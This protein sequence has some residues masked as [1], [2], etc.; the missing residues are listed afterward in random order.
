[1]PWLLLSLLVSVSPPWE[2]GESQSQDLTI[3]LVTFGP[4]DSLTQWWG[5]SGLLVAD[6]RLG[7]SRLYNY[8]MFGFEAG[9]VNQFV[10]G[11]LDFWVDDSIPVDRTFLLYANELRRD[12]RIQELNLTPAQAATAAAKLAWNVRPE[13]RRYL[14]QHYTDNCS[15]RPRD[16]I[17]EAIGGQL[18]AATSGPA[19]MTLREHTLR[20]SCVDPPM[21]LVLDYLQNGSLDGPLTQRGEAYLPDELERQVARLNVIEKDGSVRPLVRRQWV[22]FASGRK[23]PPEFPP[24]WTWELLAIGMAFLGILAGLLNPRALRFRGTR[25]IAGTGVALFGLASGILGCTLFF[26]GTFTDHL[27]AHHNENI[28]LIS[29]F[30]LVLLPVGIQLAMGKARSLARLGSAWFWLAFLT[31]IELLLKVANLLQPGLFRQANWNLLTLLIPINLGGFLVI[32]WFQRRQRR[33]SVDQLG[34]DQRLD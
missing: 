4:G 3:S 31:I 17:D 18:K 34:R 10:M 11:R 32:W 1:M 8:G 23:P 29:P 2:T 7:K 21:A 16:I 15:T 25:V 26:I 6:R 5:H 20:Y 28:L 30:N 9:F 19:R 24:N 22:E 12:I 27:V 33:V 14:Y 13:N